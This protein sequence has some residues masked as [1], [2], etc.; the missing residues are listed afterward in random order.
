MGLDRD[1]GVPSDY[2]GTI[3]QL[4]PGLNGLIAILD[5]T[6]AE[7]VETVF[8]SDAITNAE[9]SG[10]NVGRSAIVEWD[11]QGWQW[12]WTS[13]PDAEAVTV[14]AVSN[15][16]S[17]YRIWWAHDQRILYMTIPRSIVNPNQLSENAYAASASHEFPW[18]DGEEAQREKVVVILGVDTESM[19]AT[20]TVAVR[21]RFNDD[22]TVA[23]Q[24]TLGT[25][26]TD[27]HTEYVLPN[28]TT[29]TGTAFRNIKPVLDF[30]RGTDTT[31]SP[32]VNRVELYFVRKEVNRWGT[33][34]NIWIPPDGYNGVSAQTM[35]ENMIAAVESLLMVPVTWRDLALD[36][37][38]NVDPYL[39]YMDVRASTGTEYTG[40]DYSGE[41]N[42]LMIEL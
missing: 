32:D 33:S 39:Y 37:A 17:G 21:L 15:A 40:W 8:M 41:H 26:T 13:E 14:A 23:G 20:E 9:V 18:F 24:T 1:H 34:V 12:L 5:A 11:G 19:S 30:A 42:L 2:R 25:I 7:G 3:R 36:D 16:Y 29:P 28:T 10:A 27:G 35:Y 31:K 4:L 22:D 6:E 38:G